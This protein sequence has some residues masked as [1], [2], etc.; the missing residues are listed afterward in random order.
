MNSDLAKVIALIAGSLATELYRRLS[1]GDHS[2]LDQS[3]QELLDTEILSDLIRETQ[4]QRAKQE[5]K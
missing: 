5:L 4:L 2:V 1:N 3:V